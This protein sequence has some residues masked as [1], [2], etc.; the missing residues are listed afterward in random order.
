M[1]A[2]T[3][4]VISPWSS[5]KNEIGLLPLIT[6]LTPPGGEYLVKGPWMVVSM[7]YERWEEED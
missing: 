2:L 7:I 1:S 6:I 4:E 3:A 5:V